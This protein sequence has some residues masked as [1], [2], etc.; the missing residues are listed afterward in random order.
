[1]C[2][3]LKFDRDM[4]LNRALNDIHILT[5]ANS[6]AVADAKDMRVDGLGGVLEPH[7]QH[8]IGGLAAHA[9][10]ADEGGARRGHLAVELVDE[11]LAELDDVLG[12]VAKQTDGFDMGDDAVFAERQHLLGRIGHR[13]QAARGFV[14]ADVCG[15]RGQGDCDDER[16]R[17]GM[18]QLALR[19]GLGGLK[20]SENLADHRIGKLFCHDLRGMAFA[21]RGV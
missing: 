9:G 5:G 8:D 12:L 20:A 17:V 7:V 13:E 4:V 3:V 15:L 14:D 10:Q 6:G 1:M 11:L 16:E 18:I 2:M 21:R 19:L